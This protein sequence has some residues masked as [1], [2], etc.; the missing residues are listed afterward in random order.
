VDVGPAGVTIQGTTVLINSGGAAGSSA[1]SGSPSDPVAPDETGT[2]ISGEDTVYAPVAE[3]A[4]TPE[5]AEPPEEAEEADHW[6]EIELVDQ[7]DQPV[8]GERYRITLPGGSVEQGNL[9]QNG[10]ARVDG[11]E[12]GTCEITFPD[13]DRDAW[14]RI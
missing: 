10:Y 12:P 9:D 3:R 7:D 2:T 6:I 8:A 4:V 11:I 14:V 1:I 13:L 5:E